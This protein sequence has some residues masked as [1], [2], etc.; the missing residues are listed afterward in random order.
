MQAGDSD[1]DYVAYFESSGVALPGEPISTQSLLDGLDGRVSATLGDS[2]RNM[3]IINRYSIIADYPGYVCGRAKR[4]FTYS[5]TGLAI[6]ATQRCLDSW[7]GDTDQIGLVIAAT[8]SADRPLPCLGF[9][10]LAGFPGRLPD[11]ANVLNMQNM[12]CSSLIKALDIARTF[13]ALNPGKKVVVVAVEAVTGLAERLMADHYCSFKETRR[14]SDKADMAREWRNTQRFL[15]AMLFGDAAVA[16]ILGGSRDEGLLGF[17]PAV[18]ATNL[19]P[20]D[21][22]ILRMNE[23]GIHTPILEEYPFYEMSDEVPERGAAYASEILARL[24]R[25]YHLD[26]DAEKGILPKFDFYNIHTGSKKI[27]NG[28]F[29]TLDVDPLGSEA[30]ESLNVLAHCA[31]TATCSAGLMLAQHCASPARDGVGLVLAFGVGFSASAAIVGAL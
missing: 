12:G 20:A 9:E 29:R 15:F 22:E 23:G 3:E 1:D 16:F 24:S 27:L 14:M 4:D 13:I 6:A 17:G 18:H 21:T 10:L 2:V 30:Q 25:K 31:N 28:V 19:R 26:N 7:D 5:A 11:D 8:N